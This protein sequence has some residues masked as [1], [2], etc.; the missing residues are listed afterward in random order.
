M[1]TCVGGS[2]RRP[3]L[4]ALES[5]QEKTPVRRRHRLAIESLEARLALNA[6]PVLDSTI[7]LEFPISYRDIGGYFF[8]PSAASG[9]P[10]SSLIGDA[11]TVGNFADSDGDPPG[12][13][14]TGLPREDGILWYSTDN[15]TT[16]GDAGLLSPQHALVLSA[17]PENRIFFQRTDVTYSDQPFT[18]R[19]SF[20]AWDRTDGV[21]SGTTGVNTTGKPV[22]RVVQTFGVSH[23]A[24]SVLSANGTFAYRSSSTALEVWSVSDPLMPVF[25][26]ALPNVMASRVYLSGDPTLIYSISHT[27]IN[28]WW[29]RALLVVNVANP[30]APQVV[31]TVALT[32]LS[33]P[34]SLVLIPGTNRGLILSGDGMSGPRE[35]T[36]PVGEAPILGKQVDSLHG[37]REM[38]F[39]GGGR[40]AIARRAN[41]LLSVDATYLDQFSI[42]PTP[43]TEVSAAGTWTIEQSSRR[44]YVLQNTANSQ[45]ADTQVAIFEIASPGSIS[46][47]SSLQVYGSNLWLHPMGGKLVVEALVFNAAAPHHGGFR[48]QWFVFAVSG[49]A[50]P[51]FLGAIDMSGRVNAGVSEWKGSLWLTGEPASVISFGEMTEAPTSAYSVKV[52]TASFSYQDTPAQFIGDASG[53]LTVGRIARGAFRYNDADTPD[54]KRGAEVIASGA[55]G[56]ATLIRLVGETLWFYD[57]GPSFPGQDS[58]TVRLYDRLGGFTDQVISVTGEPSRRG[59]TIAN[60]RV[61]QNRGEAMASYV[62]PAEGVLGQPVG[63]VPTRISAVSADTS[64][65]PH[66]VTIYTSQNQPSNISF[67]PVAGASGVVEIAIEVEDG[68]P[69]SDLLTVADNGV[70]SYT[71]EVEVL[72]VISTSSSGVLGKD[73]AGK[74]Y[75]NTAPIFYGDTQ[76]GSTVGGFTVSGLA[77]D[78]QTLLAVRDGNTYKVNAD[79]EWRIHSLFH[80]LSNPASVFLEPIDRRVISVTA[81]TAAFVIAEEENPDLLF[82]RGD[83]YEFSLDTPGHAF[84]LQTVAGQF[85]AAFVY[86][87]GF[88]GNGQTSGRWRWTVPTDAPAELYYVSEANESLRGRLLI[89]D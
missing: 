36:F 16:W 58:F 27:I 84:Y 56:D 39:V 82:R 49:G 17:S 51:E 11:A 1:L 8:T 57:A 31:H 76:A 32:G 13:A 74:I 23:P 44:L 10:V 50:Q 3:S 33:N 25:L 34:T 72:Q 47:V 43:I 61:N 83:T 14:I 59:G 87:V 9:I 88:D 21:V 71:I 86:S 20:K 26:G 62:I 89:V 73:S 2:L 46:H 12:I 65:I 53:V 15:G 37:V 55:H 6:A 64:I 85:Q 29:T 79:E 18:G 5:Q 63:N 78:S 70:T 48:R 81:S 24:G 38:V 60:M 22:S 52:A 7:P 4:F 42:A 77:R 35:V 28:D 41:E 45:I 68:G 19:M 40:H 69:D 66:P 30:T 54:E 75:A 67:T 80:S